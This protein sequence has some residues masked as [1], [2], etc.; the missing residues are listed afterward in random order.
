MRPVLTDYMN[1]TGEITFVTRIHN[2]LV[3]AEDDQLFVT[4]PQNLNRATSGLQHF[5]YQNQSAIIGA[6]GICM[7]SS[8]AIQ[9]L[10]E[11]ERETIPVPLHK[12][13]HILFRDKSGVFSVYDTSRTFISTTFKYP[14]PKDIISF[15]GSNEIPGEFAVVE[16]HSFKLCKLGYNTFEIINEIEIPTCFKV[17]AFHGSYL[18]Q[19]E[20]KIV[21]YKDGNLDDFYKVTSGKTKEIKDFKVD[22]DRV[23]ALTVDGENCIIRVIGTKSVGIRKFASVGNWDA[24]DG[25]MTFYLKGDLL[26]FINIENPD[27]KQVVN[28]NGLG[29]LPMKIASGNSR[30]NEKYHVSLV[31]PNTMAFITIPFPLLTGEVT[32]EPLDDAIRKSYQ[33]IKA[34]RKSTK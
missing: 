10:P 16:R 24:H 4:S 19:L 30:Y 6:T 29:G 20:D 21:R 3:L 27:I 7:D 8:I 22:D 11:N 34:L 28:L 32:P 18:L 5:K 13:L 23:I 15:A 2:S 12:E 14:K 9:N 17:L 1:L 33:T 25:W 26:A 31:Y